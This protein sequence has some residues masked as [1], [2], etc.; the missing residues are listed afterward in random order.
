VCP[1]E[2]KKSLWKGTLQKKEKIRKREDI[3][4]GGKHPL[5]LEHVPGKS[6]ENVEEAVCLEGGDLTNGGPE[7]EMTITRR[8]KCT[9]EKQA[10]SRGVLHFSKK[11]GKK[12]IPRGDSQ[13]KESPLMGGVSGRGRKGLEKIC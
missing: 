5:K 11:G 2:G 8:E 7:A 13:C 3:N 4:E 10:T 9:E 1:K 6:A 12:K